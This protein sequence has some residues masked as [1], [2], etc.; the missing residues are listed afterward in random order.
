MNQCF[1]RTHGIIEKLVTHS[2]ICSRWFYSLS[3]WITIKPPFR[4]VLL[5]F[6]NH[7]KQI[8]GNHPFV[9]AKATTS[10]LLH[11]YSGPRFST[12]FPPAWSDFP[13]Y[14]TEDETDRV[15]ISRAIILGKIPGNSWWVSTLAPAGVCI[16]IYI[17]NLYKQIDRLKINR[18]RKN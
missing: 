18:W 14:L 9:V 5:T 4:I 2:W 16:Y 3:W 7:L 8:H 11:Q 17:Y 1:G 12:T 13:R 10:W 6:S 15:F